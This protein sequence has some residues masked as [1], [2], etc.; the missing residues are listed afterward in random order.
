MA[1]MLNG[2]SFW[3]A[4]KVFRIFRKNS[5]LNNNKSTHQFQCND[6]FYMFPLFFCPTDDMHF[7][8]ITSYFRSCLFVYLTE[9]SSTFSDY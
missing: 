9:I 7:P 5:R 3:T 1:L 8:M 2:F 4:K 6:I